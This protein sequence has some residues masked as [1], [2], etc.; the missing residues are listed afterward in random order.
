MSEP[1]VSVIVA[2]YQAQRTLP[3]LL[4]ALARQDAKFAFE[5]VVVDDGS[6][7]E[8]A[9]LARAAGVRVVSQDN[10]GPA[11]ARNR[12]WREA[13]A[14]RILFTDS[15]CVP[16]RDWVR[17]MNAALADGFDVAGGSYGIANPGHLLA[18]CVHAEIRWRHSRLP[19]SVEFAGS[20]NLGATR[21]ALEAVNGFD[22]TYPTAS[23]EDNDLS[24]R[25]RDAG[26]RIRFVPAALVDH[27]HPTSLGRYL[28][29]QAR[30]G[31]WRMVLYASHPLR[32]RGDGYAGPVDFMAPPVAVMSAL[33][34]LVAFVRPEALALALLT[35]S[36]VGLLQ[37]ALAMQVA[38]H[39][40]SSTPLAL[41]PIATLRAYARGWGLVWG[42][43]RVAFRRKRPR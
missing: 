28:G 6:T 18:D 8:T 19:E 9:A 22:E 11:A 41:A 40:R 2:A 36:T 3:A 37:S 4:D 15:D 39:S 34:T 13:N 16:H 29:E 33:F 27:H 42:L 35:A 20:F 31:Y 32:A 43:A 23:G 30:H 7:D 17:R 21:E 24:Y 38:A 12:G 14:D 10:A 25:L 26:F 5:T 1:V